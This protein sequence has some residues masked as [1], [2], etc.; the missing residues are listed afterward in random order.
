MVS[1]EDFEVVPIILICGVIGII[2]AMIFHTLND[3]GIIID[4][5]IT[6]SITITN[7]MALVIVIWLIV[8]I[9]I[10]AVKK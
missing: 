3:E 9:I 10:A 4:E 6:G 7:L 8:G 2:N 5:F 1:W